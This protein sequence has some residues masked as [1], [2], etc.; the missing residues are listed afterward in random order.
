MLFLRYE[1]LREYLRLYPVTTLVL[2][3][4]LALFAAM[5]LAGGSANPETLLRFGALVNEYP[6]TE[7]WWRYVSSLFLHIGFNH[8]LFNGFAIF[9]FGPPLERLL[10]KIRYAVFYLASGIGGN[11]LSEA[12]YAEPH[13][14]A[15]ASGSIFGIYGAFLY[16][17]LFRKHLLDRP[18]RQTIVTIVAIGLVYSFVVPHINIYAHIGGGICGFLLVSI[19]HKI[20]P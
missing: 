13:I 6:Y 10:G 9:V 14:S 17:A 16:F 8:I 19:L 4:N 18:S 1:S 20:G 15:G 7:Q 5:T 11:A 3:I 2:L 12:L